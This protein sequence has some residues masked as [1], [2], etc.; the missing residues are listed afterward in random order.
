[1]D[2]TTWVEIDRVCSQRRDCCGCPYKSTEIQAKTK[3]WYVY[4]RDCARHITVGLKVLLV[5][6]RVWGVS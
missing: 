3:A 5:N 4:S 1:M 2:K 6:L